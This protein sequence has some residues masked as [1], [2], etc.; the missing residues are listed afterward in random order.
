[1]GKH[2]ELLEARNVFKN[3]KMLAKNRKRYE[4][5]RGLKLLD[6]QGSFE[7]VDNVGS[8]GCYGSVGK[9][10]SLGNS[11][12]A[13]IIPQMPTIFWTVREASKDQKLLERQLAS[14][15]VSKGV[16]LETA[17]KK[18]VICNWW[19]LDSL[20]TSWRYPLF[21]RISVHCSPHWQEVAFREFKE[22]LG[23]KLYLPQE[24]PTDWTHNKPTPFDFQMKIILIVSS[25]SNLSL[26]NSVLI[27]W[28]IK[29]Y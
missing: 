27:S 5:S 19:K 20:W 17:G 23:R 28:D 10:L 1:M 9:Q 26:N 13:V 15:T 12:K 16:R 8:R 6:T 7:T 29:R 25:C 4:N 11:Q 18:V 14:K 24:D 3:N 21:I 2:R 22:V